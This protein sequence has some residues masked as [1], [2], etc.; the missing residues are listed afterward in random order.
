MRGPE[1]LIFGLRAHI[2]SSYVADDEGKDSRR[3][4]RAARAKS[5]KG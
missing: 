3:A 5:K 1:D 4:K 2:V